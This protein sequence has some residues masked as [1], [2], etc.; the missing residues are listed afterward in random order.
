MKT[1]FLFNH[2]SGMKFVDPNKQIFLELIKDGLIVYEKKNEVLMEINNNQINDA[3]VV[4]ENGKEIFILKTNEVE[5]SLESIVKGYPQ[6]AKQNILDNK[7]DSEAF[8]QKNEEE[9]EKRKKNNQLVKNI[10]LYI[11]GISYI[12]S[13]V[14]IVDIP[15]STILSVLA[16]I[17]LLPI[18]SENI[19]KKIAFLDVKRN[20]IILTILL[21]FLSV[22][23]LPQTTKAYIKIDNTIICGEPDGDTGYKKM[24]VMDE[25]NVYKKH[26][27]KNGFLKTEDNAYV[28][29]DNIAFEGTPE[30]QEA[31]KNKELKDKKIKEEKAKKE[32]AK[33]EAEKLVT[34]ALDEKEK[35]L[36]KIIYDMFDDVEITN[37]TFNYYVNPISWYNSSL[38]D[39][40]NAMN[41][42]AVYG[43]LKTKQ[44]DLSE[45][46]ALIRVKIL[47]STNGKT[48]GKY[49]VFKGYEFE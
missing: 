5:I 31:K 26:F 27:K 22:I 41:G 23:F 9:K 13:I 14:N 45:E 8:W 4:N 39:K 34:K 15:L 35:Q 21:L 47:D 7:K 29:E 20:R 2:L 19:G 40:K 17:M 6:L 37:Y 18:I 10:I 33:Q 1:M 36:K 12:L 11:L 43:K 38:N 16:G 28:K 32:K 30:Y 25:I 48:L 42:C 44:Y 49:S 46:L 24:A 3:I